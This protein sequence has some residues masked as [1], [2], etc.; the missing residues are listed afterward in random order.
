MA[1]APAALRAALEGRPIDHPLRAPLLAAL[2]A[3]VEELDLRDF[4]ADAGK[5]SRIL[6]GLASSLGIDVLVLDSG[7]GWDAESSGFVTDWGDGYPPSIHAAAGVDLRF[8]PARG[9]A[10][11]ILDLLGRARAVVSDSV[12]LAVTL[13]GPGALG[14]PTATQLVLAAAR[15]VAEAGAG[16][17]IVREEGGDEVDCAAYRAATAPLWRSLQFF[18]S[19][20]VLQ[21]GGRADAWADVLAGAGPFLPVFNALQSPAAAAA[22][23]RAGR[24][25]GLA[26]AADAGGSPVGPLA[27]DRCALLTHDRDLAGQVPVRD[28]AGV[29]AAMTIGSIFSS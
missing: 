5:R 7:S 11:V 15:A 28:A 25:Y 21:V 2:A 23:A 6:A 19:V 14:T 16:V 8:D 29:V 24:P 1:G 27:T 3:E 9:G 13:T 10:P 20:G 18:R 12:S 4:L 17:V 26:L 22:V